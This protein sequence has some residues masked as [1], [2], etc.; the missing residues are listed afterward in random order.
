MAYKS[1]LLHLDSSKACKAR[2]TAAVAT[3]EAQGGHLIGLFPTA[4]P[5]IPAFVGASLPV[6]LLDQQAKQAAE[7]A[8][9]GLARFAKACSA[10][11]LSYEERKARCFPGRGGRLC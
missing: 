2:V 8:D 11:G 7:A 3:A 6:D 4:E 1:I 10:A 9:S 5:T